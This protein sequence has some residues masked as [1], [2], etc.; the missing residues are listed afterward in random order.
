[1]HVFTLS[2]DILVVE[3]IK[4]V[5]RIFKKKDKNKYMFF[6]DVG[7]G[8]DSW[9][10]FSDEK[11]ETVKEKHSTLLSLINAPDM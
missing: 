8:K 2:G 7:G 3:N 4:R 5:S 10:W 11:E 6:V 1:M 9:V